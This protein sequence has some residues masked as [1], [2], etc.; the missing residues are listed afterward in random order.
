MRMVRKVTVDVVYAMN[1]GVPYTL[2]QHKLESQLEEKLKSAGLRVLSKS[3][4]AN[5][6]E[7]NPV[8]KLY[9]YA[10]PVS[11][12]GGAV[13]AC[14]YRI[15]V[16][17]HQA[18]RVPLN[19]SAAPVEL[20]HSGNIGFSLKESFAQ[21]IQAMVDRISSELVARLQVDNGKS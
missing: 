14:T 6:K 19:G 16:S 11:A 9:V 21:D 15:D 13:V 8:V 2:S 12:E 20:W 5:D 7:N 1:V 17:V 18:G 3:L 4:D 10:L